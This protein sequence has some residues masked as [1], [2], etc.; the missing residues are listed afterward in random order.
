MY[1][2]RQADLPGSCAYY[3][4]RVSVIIP[5]PSSR[6]PIIHQTYFLPLPPFLST[7]SSLARHFRSEPTE[8]DSMDGWQSG[9]DGSAVEAWR[10]NASTDGKGKGRE[11]DV[12]LLDGLVAGIEV[13]PLRG[14]L[15]HE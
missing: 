1:G 3:Q 11:D 2:E 5:G 13:C 12:G 6:N 4:L 9:D 14:N 7:L 15:R 10:E 8:V